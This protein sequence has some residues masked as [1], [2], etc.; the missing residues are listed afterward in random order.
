ME[1]LKEYNNLPQK[2]KSLVIPLIIVFPFWLVAIY[3]LNKPFYQQ[4]DYLILGSFCFCFSITWHFLN[5]IIAIVTSV[6][7]KRNKSIEEIA[8]VSGSGSVIYLSFSIL[9]AYYFELK[10]ITFLFIA[11]A[12]MVV[13]YFRAIFRLELQKGVES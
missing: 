5:V 6:R 7:L 13:L 4:K 3:L 11:Y 2:T 12:Y 1:W 8:F 10:F 9:T